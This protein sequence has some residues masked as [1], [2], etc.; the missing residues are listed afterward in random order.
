MLTGGCLCGA[1]RY[2]ADGDP[3]WTAICYCRDCQR[4]SGSGYVPVMGAPR[5]RMRI[6][7]EM[8]HFDAPAANGNIATRHFCPTCGSLVLGGILD[9]M[10]GTISIYIGTLDDPSA[11]KPQIAIFTKHRLPWDCT[12]AGVTEFSA[13]PGMDG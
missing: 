2:E 13:M 10:A 11:F 3:A 8:A 7:G 4:S 1:V 9:D 12:A 6:T 5:A